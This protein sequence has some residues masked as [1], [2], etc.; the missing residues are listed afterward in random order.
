[1]QN[2]INNLGEYVIDRSVEIRNGQYGKWNYQKDKE[3]RFV[4]MGTAVY[5]EKILINADTSERALMLK[6][7]DAKGEECTVT[8]ER[9]KL[10]DVGIMELLANGVQRM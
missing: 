6:F 2:R 4:P 9:K 1:M 8:I 7:A 3:P 10:T 5:L